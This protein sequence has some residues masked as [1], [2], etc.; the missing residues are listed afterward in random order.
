LKA[1]DY[2]SPAV[3][4]LRQQSGH[5]HVST[6]GQDFF[7]VLYEFTIPRL[8]VA[9]YLVDCTPPM[10]FCSIGG[11]SLAFPDEVGSLTDGLFEVSIRV[12]HFSFS[13]GGRTWTKGA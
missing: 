1:G 10:I 5:I 9:Q 4:V 12:R 11:T 13:L 8:A 2:P 3:N 7:F 6:P